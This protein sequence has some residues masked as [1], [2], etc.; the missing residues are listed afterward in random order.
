VA[1]LFD[2][3]A[4]GRPPP[5]AASK[6]SHKEDAQRLLDWLQ[7]QTK[8]TISMRDIRIYGPGSIRDP[9]SAI[10]AAEVLVR[11]GW[12]IPLKPHRYDM[13]KWQVVRK[14]IAQPTVAAEM[15]K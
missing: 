13:H 12:L 1:S 15:T 11:N 2:R 14:P 7:R 8:S 4:K 5:E 6:Q 9:K 3:L 10:A